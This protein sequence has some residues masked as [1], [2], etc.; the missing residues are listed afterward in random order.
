M[1]IHSVVCITRCLYAVCTT[2]HIYGPCAD[3]ADRST[4]TIE[5][6]GGETT[7]VNPVPAEASAAAAAQVDTQTL[8][9]DIRTTSQAQAEEM[10]QRLH[11]ASGL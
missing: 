7:P 6:D 9:F 3:E 1:S 10:A 11:G 8:H 5:Q 4:W 2:I